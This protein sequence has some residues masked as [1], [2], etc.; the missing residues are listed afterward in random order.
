MSVESVSISDWED[1]L[2]KSISHHGLA[3]SPQEILAVLADAAETS[4]PMTSGD[5]EFATTYAG[6]SD[7]DLSAHALA[8]ADIE[9]ASTRAAAAQEVKRDA[10]N[11]QEVAGLLGTSPANVRRSV[12]EGSLYSV[13]TS[14][15]SHHLFPRW[16]FPHE[17]ALPCL[18]AVISALPNNYHPL[19]VRAFMTE[20]ADELRGMSPVTWLAEGGNVDDVVRLAD[21]RAWD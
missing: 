21:D 8:A 1:R 9:I 19:E 3:V 16:Q 7:E 10:L 5:R 20:P 2:S 17:H 14:P 13:T 15:G 12:S 11:T 6:L 18:R 4:A